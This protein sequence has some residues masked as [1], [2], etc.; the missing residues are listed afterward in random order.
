[1]ALDPFEVDLYNHAREKVKRA[2]NDVCELVS[3]N[4]TKA[5]I[6]LMASTVCIGAAAAHLSH[7]AE[8]RGF[9]MT[10]KE[11]FAAVLKLMGEQ[12]HEH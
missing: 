2:L 8:R 5:R 9:T 10:E 11:S 7:S 6:A 4:G 1:M 3:D 12:V